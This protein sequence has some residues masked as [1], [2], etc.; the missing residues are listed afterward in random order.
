[1]NFEKFSAILSSDVACTPFSPLFFWD[2]NFIDINLGFMCCFPFFFCL[3]FSLHISPWCSIQWVSF[4]AASLITGRDSTIPKVAFGLH[5]VAQCLVYYA[6]SFGS[7]LWS[8][9]RRSGLLPGAL[10]L[11]RPWPSIFAC[12]AL[13]DCNFVV[14]WLFA[15]HK[16]VREE[17][18]IRLS[19]LHSHGPSNLC[20]FI[21]L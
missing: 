15:I 6:Y 10:S 18:S 13:W 20:A 3:W 5:G 9:N 21:V 14:F 7:A 12:P 16:W 11:S 4:D 19:S 1:M 17:A 8:P 2:S